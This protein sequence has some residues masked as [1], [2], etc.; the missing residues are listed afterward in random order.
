M[1]LQTFHAFACFFEDARDWYTHTYHHQRV[2][3]KTED[4]SLFFGEEKGLFLTREE[5]G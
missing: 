3:S 2:L 4:L 1:D 5:P